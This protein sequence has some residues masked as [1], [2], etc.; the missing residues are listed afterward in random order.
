M[1]LA[2]HVL[3]TTDT[4]NSNLWAYT[5]ELACG[6]VGRGMR[7]TLVSFGEIPLPEQ[8]TWMD[9]LRG[10]DYRPTAF[11]LD[12]MQEGQ[13]DFAESSEYLC[14]L[15]NEL[16]P[17]VFHSNQLCYG[18]LPVEMPRVAV[19]H[20]D[21]LTWWKSVH[22][23][24]PKD[25]AWM[26]WYRNTTAIGLSQASAV[27]ASSE[28]M[29]Q[30][31]GNAYLA[32]MN[33]TVINHGRNPIHFNPYVT[34][35]DTVLAVGRLLDPAAQV[36][37]LADRTHPVPVCV[38]D[39]KQPEHR[40]ETQVRADV[41]FNN[42]TEGVVMRGAHSETQLRLLYSRASMYVS[43]SRYEPSGMTILEAALSR[44]ALIL[45]DIPALREI[46]GP[47]AVYFRTN[48]GDSLCEAVRILNSDPDL[49]RSFANRAFNR[50]RECFNANRMTS[51]Y[52][53]LY[54][55]LIAQNANAA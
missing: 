21:F 45:N 4:L 13:Q 3:M 28:W 22:G 47:A 31:I 1:R 11:R 52:I 12:W 36:N 8:T 7:V 27:V 46:W 20:G 19:S 6:L 9:R 53:Q 40:P 33:G 5:R 26:R 41:R 24:D 51:N 37:L 2:M 38:V 10:L 54:R 14:A 23:R 15:L 43:A 55:S 39:A 17:D 42:G 48:D 34:K 32:P 35:D 44:C 29:L 25:S 30:A 49:R 50:A 18:A 16:K